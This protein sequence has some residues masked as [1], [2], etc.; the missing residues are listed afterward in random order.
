MK[1]NDFKAIYKW[2]SAL[3]IHTMEE[4]EWFK[5]TFTDGTNADLLNKS[6]WHFINRS[7][8]IELK[9]SEDFSVCCDVVLP[10][11]ASKVVALKRARRDAWNKYVVNNPIVQKR[12][13]KLHTINLEGKQ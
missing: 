7:T 13:E 8:Y 9:L 2:L 4:F 10:I 12:Y 11:T 3:G 6:N 5:R 1:Y